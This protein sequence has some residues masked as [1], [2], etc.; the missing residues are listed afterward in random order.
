MS[1]IDLVP[2]TQQCKGCPARVAWCRT[3]KGKAIPI[4]LEPTKSGNIVLEQPDP[5]DAPIARV[6]RSNL[7]PDTPRYVAHFA[8]CSAAERFRK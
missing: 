5:R 7:L 2:W 3:E 1:A 8:T 6:V 4:D